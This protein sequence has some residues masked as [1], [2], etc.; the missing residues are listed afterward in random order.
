MHLVSSPLPNETDTRV[1]SAT[2]IL[3][4]PRSR[5]GAGVANDI[6][7]GSAGAINVIS[8]AISYTCMIRQDVCFEKDVLNL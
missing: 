5:D 3:T 6:D 1:V 8:C 4:S 2:G 7:G